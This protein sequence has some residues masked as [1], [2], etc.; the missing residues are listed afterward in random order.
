MRMAQAAWGFGC[1]DVESSPRSAE[2]RVSGRRTTDEPSVRIGL[3]RDTSVLSALES[4]Q[5]F[6]TNEA[7]LCRCPKLSRCPKSCSSVAGRSCSPVALSVSALGRTAATREQG[8]QMVHHTVS[9]LER[10]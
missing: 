3:R 6:S 10:R 9:P 5:V 1:R 7:R 8:E 4:V 2:G